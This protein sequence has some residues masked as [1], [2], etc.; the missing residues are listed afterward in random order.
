MPG[1]TRRL[2]AV[3][4]IAIVCIGVAWMAAVLEAQGR[5]Q[6]SPASVRP[7]QTKSPQEY[8]AAQIEAG[9]TQFASQCGFC[10][11]RDA[12]GGA[13]GTDL[14]RSTLV[15]EDTRGDRDRKS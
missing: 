2:G 15:A 5:G 14:T 11:G 6:A 9:R 8:P 12:A 10:H 7:P 13:G 4:H 1:C 3:S